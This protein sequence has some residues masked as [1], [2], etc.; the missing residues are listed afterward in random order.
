MTDPFV[1][2]HFNIRD[3]NWILP[4]SFCLQYDGCVH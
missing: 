4:R 1:I 2:W 3:D